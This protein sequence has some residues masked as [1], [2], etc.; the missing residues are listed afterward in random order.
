MNTPSKKVQ[1]SGRGN[2]KPEFLRGEKIKSKK[3]R[4]SGKSNHT[5]KVGRVNSGINYNIHGY[6]GGKRP[7]DVL[8]IPVVLRNLKHIIEERIRAL[9]F[10]AGELFGFLSWLG[11]KFAGFLLG[12][13]AFPVRV[14]NQTSRRLGRKVI[15]CVPAI[16]ALVLVG[17]A[18]FKGAFSE[19]S[20]RN[21]YRSGMTRAL[22][23]G[24]Y[25][26]AK[27]FGERLMA[28]SGEIKPAD[29]LDYATCLFKQG[30]FALALE[31][32]N[33]LA[34]NDRLGYPPAHRAKAVLLTQEYERTRDN[35]LL[36]RLYYHLT[37][38]DEQSS[39]SI[40]RGYAIYFVATNQPSRAI[41]YLTSAVQENP[42]L[43]PNL[44]ALYQ[45]TN[46]PTLYRE[47]LRKAASVLPKLLNQDPANT[48]LR[49]EYAKLL[50]NMDRNEDAL[51]VLKQGCES[52]PDPD[53]KRAIAD[54]YLMRYD[55][56]PVFE[57]QLKLIEQSWSYD[58]NNITSYL[59]LVT[60]FQ[61]LKD[62]DDDNRHRIADLI[63]SQTTLPDPPAVAFYALSNLNFMTGDTEQYQIN[64]MK[65]FE[66]DPQFSVVANN[67]AW[68]L[69]HDQEVLDLEKANSLASELVQKFPTNPRFRDTYGTILMK[70]GKFKEALS[71]LE[72]I[73]NQVP[74]KGAVHLKLAEIYEHL[75][76]P[77]LA[78]IHREKYNAHARVPKQ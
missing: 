9:R 2:A 13:A 1:E 65:S 4:F 32:L 45:Q 38:S 56:E 44:L 21:R 52:N 42:E 64:L 77:A 48:P 74:D 22:E 6:C 35:L 19:D 34:P 28:L 24:D 71:Q 15:W 14:F 12:L 29:Q 78:K 27:A 30:E 69:A 10:Q 50:V 36:D 18:T 5:H 55:Q 46:Q 37:Q 51:A 60:D 75:Q 23:T 58:P 62:I 7:R 31:N 3:V 66:R 73:L 68:L 49:I 39:Y 43:Y 59:K 54:F 76:K 25:T 17:V 47:T 61:A 33:A 20:L 57:E 53:L 67:V 41:P 63:K 70:Q 72:P 40:C 8:R 16:I 26:K 11:G